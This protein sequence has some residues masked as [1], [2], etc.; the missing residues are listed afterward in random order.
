MK[1][2][3]LDKQNF[4]ELS[5][6]EEEEELVFVMKCTNLKIPINYSRYP[7]YEIS[8]FLNTYTYTKM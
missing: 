8:K 1:W 3:H 7:K 6:L 2:G 4:P 5:E